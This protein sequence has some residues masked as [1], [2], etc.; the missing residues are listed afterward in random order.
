MI[1]TF[2]TVLLGFIFGV[3]GAYALIIYFPNSFKKNEQTRPQV[4]NTNLIV[5]KG[6]KEVLGFLPYF[7]LDK[8]RDDYSSYIT[9][10]NYFG[11]IIDKDGTILKSN[12]PIELEP[13][14]YA[15]TS[16]KL[17]PFFDKAKAKGVKLSLTV[18]DGDKDIISNLIS[19]PII[20]AH[21]FVNDIIPVLS[22]YGFSDLNLDIESIGVATPS[23]QANYESFVAEIRNQMIAR[24]LNVSLSMDIIP[25]DFVR[26]DHLAL[27]ENLAKYL[28]KIIIMAYDFHSPSS[29]VTGPVAP[30]YGAGSIAE[31]DTQ[32]AIA[33]A[34]KNYDSSKIL[35]GV[36]FY[37]YSWETIDNFERAAIVPASVVIES[38]RDVTDILSKCASCSAQF[39][40]IAQEKY[41][42]YKNED[43][44]TYSQIFYPDADAIKSKINFV[45]GNNLG[46]LAIWALGYESATPSANSILS[47]IQTF[48]KSR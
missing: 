17:D 36:P 39:D 21:N 24:N 26:K 6:K 10:L 9:T 18:F 38:E 7:L 16:G 43:T 19:D 31:F 45:N 47:P 25:V 28:D 48:L 32:V 5:P 35:L 41:V 3:L 11:L 2:L 37:G 22:K 15:L 14:Y 20:H 23:A 12:N 30:L 1:R 8:A 40:D 4:V 13:G 42:I 44:G 33:A 27:P 34:L 46:G 29:F